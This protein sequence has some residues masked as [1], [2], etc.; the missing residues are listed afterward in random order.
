MLVKTLYNGCLSSVAV[1][2]GVACLPH[3]ADQEWWPLAISSLKVQE[4]QSGWCVENHSPATLTAILGGVS[5]WKVTRPTW[6]TSS[7]SEP[8]THFSCIH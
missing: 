2:L 6:L 1:E 5:A 3:S 4:W 7:Y 8:I